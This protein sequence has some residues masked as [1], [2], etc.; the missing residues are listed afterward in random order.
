MSRVQVPSSLNMLKISISKKTIIIIYAIINFLTIEISPSFFIPINMQMFLR[1]TLGFKKCEDKVFYISTATVTPFI[2]WYLLWC[3]STY[4]LDCPIVV[5]SDEL[6]ALTSVDLVLHYGFISRPSLFLQT[7]LIAEM[8]ALNMGVDIDINRFNIFVIIR[9]FIDSNLH[10]LLFVVASFIL[11]LLL[12]FF[13]KKSIRTYALL[14]CITIGISPSLSIPINMLM[15]LIY[16]LRFEK[17]KSKMV[18][19][20]TATSTPFICW[21]LL[22]CVSTYNIDFPL[23]VGSDEFTVT[24]NELLRNYD[25]ILMPS[26]CFQTLLIADVLA[27]KIGLGFDISCFNIFV[28]IVAFINTNLHSLLFVVTSVILLLLFFFNK[29]IILYALLNCITIGISPLLFIP[30]N[31]QIFLLYTLRFKK[32]ESNVFYKV[33]YIVV[34]TSTPFICWYLLWCVSTYNIGFPLLVGSDEFAVTNNELLRNRGIILIPSLFFQTLLIADVLAVKIG[35]VFDINCF[36]IF[37]I[38]VAFI[39][40][41]LHPLLYFYRHMSLPDLPDIARWIFLI[42]DFVVL[43]ITEADSSTIPYVVVSFILLLMV[44]ATFLKK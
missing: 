23:L 16:T 2:C 38:I 27:V 43:L 41:N 14:N 37:V 20:V 24:N 44:C 21:Y 40:T 18:Y 4:H 5:G 8:F 32:C 11:F 17:C 3:V 10:S 29:I 9:G 34:A 31:M 39:N 1:Y 42:V 25:I 13:F 28:I 12:L 15:F 35:L 19:I 30:I 7:L 22:W 26:L 33:F 6:F 36:N